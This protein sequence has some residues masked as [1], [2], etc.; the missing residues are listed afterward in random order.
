MSF[1]LQL[2]TP[3]PAR[4]ARLLTRARRTLERRSKP[5]QIPVAVLVE[6]VVVG[7]VALVYLVAVL[8]VAI[9][10]PLVG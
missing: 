6:R 7:G 8:Q 4:S 1:D 3:H 5:R 10:I 2:L 9:S